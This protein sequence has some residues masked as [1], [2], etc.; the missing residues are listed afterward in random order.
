MKQ[1]A[2]WNP[3]RQA[4]ENPHGS[5]DLFSML[6]DVFLGTWP[7]WGM[8]RTGVVFELPTRAHRTGGIGF[9]YLPT[10]NAALLTSNLELQKSGDGRETPNKLGW[11][12]ALLKTPTSQ[13]A[14]N[15]GSQHPDKRKEGGH[16]PTLADEV[17]HLLPTPTAMDS[18]ASGGSSPSNLTLTDAVVRTSLGATTN[19]RFDGGKP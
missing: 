16:G 10:P 14:I 18:K 8:T 15:G 2:I 4:W 17:E 7:S 6:S 11:A 13:L 19:P 3:Q 1:I 12:V 9:S 5:V